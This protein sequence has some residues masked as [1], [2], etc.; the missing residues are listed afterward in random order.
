M[1][2]DIGKF[3]LLGADASCKARRGRLHT[4]H[5]TVETPVFM[6]V[7]TQASVKALSQEDLKAIGAEI[8]LGNAYHLFLR[9]GLET[10]EAAGGIHEFMGWDRPLL[11]DSGGYQVFSLSKLNK[12]TAEGVTFQSHLDGT[13]HHFSPGRAIEVQHTFLLLLLS[14]KRFRGT[15]VPIRGAGIL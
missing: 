4:A 5:G 6:P 7:G 12:V 15:P 8:I 3:E 10:L 1:N 9:P 13:R 14:Q 2:S 11:T